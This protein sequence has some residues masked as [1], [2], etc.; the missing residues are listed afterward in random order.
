MLSA[1]YKEEILGGLATVKRSW[2]LARVL[3]SLGL[4][5][6]ERFWKLAGVKRP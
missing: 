5:S 2:E 6:V 4:A 1:G 3:R